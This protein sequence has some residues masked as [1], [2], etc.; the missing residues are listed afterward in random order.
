MIQS[1]AAG[2]CAARIVYPDGIG[3]TG[4]DRESMSI[5]WVDYHGSLET[6]LWMIPNPDSIGNDV[7]P[8]LAGRNPTTKDENPGCR[9]VTE[10][11]ADLQTSQSIQLSETHLS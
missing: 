8:L 7:I 9:F 5:T 4:K 1:V 3:I 2:G 6:V 10:L 11:N